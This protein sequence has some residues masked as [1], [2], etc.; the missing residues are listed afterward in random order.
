MAGDESSA[1][2]YRALVDRCQSL[3]ESYA[4][5]SEKLDQ[6]VDLK[7]KEK[8]EAT[9]GGS[10]PGDMAPECSGRGIF[11]G[12]FSSGNPYKSALDSLGH[13]VHVC[14]ASSGMIVY[15]NCSAENLYGWKE[16]EVVGRRTFCELLIPEEYYMSLQKILRSLCTG[17]GWS[18]QFPFKKR[19][20]ETF[21][22]LV[23][24]S[25]LYENGEIAGVITVASDAT[26]FNRMEE[27]KLR[28]YKD[29]DSRKRRE[30]HSN[31]KKIQWH[32]RPPIA[33]VP[34]MVSSVSNL[35]AKV[36][37]K[38]Q[39]K[40]TGSS[41]NE[42]DGSTRQ[43]DISDSSPVSN[44]VTQEPCSPTDSKTSK[45]EWGVDSDYKGERPQKINSSLAAQRGHADEYGCELSNVVEQGYG[46][47]PSNECSDCFGS[48]KNGNPLERFG[49]HVNA[50]VAE[51]EVP[52]LEAV[53]IEDEVQKLGKQFRS[54]EGSI[55]SLGSSSSKGDD[56]STS[57]VDC[58]IHWEDLHLGEEIG[59]GFYAI[60]YRG[61]WNGS[62][63]AVKVF[64][65]N[66][67]SEGALQDYK[68]E[69]NIM[70]RLRHPNVLLFMGA[71][72]SQERLAI[73][74]EFLPRGSLFKTLHKNNQSLD[75]RRRLRM[76]LDVA[77][78]MNYLHRRN[79]PIV[80][81]DLKSSNLLVDKNWTVKVGDFGLSRL[82]NATFL[83]A[84]SG[85]GTPQWMAPE[86]LR[87]EPSNEKS[88]VF[89]FGVILWELMTESFPWNNLNALQVVGVVGFMDRRLELPDDLDPQVASIIRDCWKRYI[90]LLFVFS[91][92]PKVASFSNI[93]LCNTK[94]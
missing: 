47:S 30:R 3:E 51:P 90:I 92:L 43:N 13:A 28:T 2:L 31:F 25:P 85:R 12:Y 72:Y 17:E 84:K 11:P 64:L 88:D 52:N 4:S 74:T 62:E 49:S 59:Q 93:V 82:K 16:Y 6:L 83:T 75:I 63:V 86:V 80:H 34:D 67:Y 79:P 46:F 50:T 73:V 24:K 60:V 58:E 66:E 76:G 87:N 56:D 70:K 23:T 7:R 41:G 36:L 15:W 5:I 42:D 77:R 19:S 81:R 35:A 94:Q 78:G 53:Q 40:G 68:K 89:S 91:T 9:V 8:E 20:G 71:A 1:I 57:V 26:W 45:S 32:R 10:D 29:G 39:I 54:S 27:Q 55:G 61:L 38:L 18:G 14:K 33:P 69:I 37:A 65:R 48:S 21:M 44:A 22:A